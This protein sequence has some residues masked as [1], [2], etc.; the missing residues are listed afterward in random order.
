MRIQVLLDSL[1]EQ[2]ALHAVQS[3]INIT[4]G[5]SRPQIDFEYVYD[6]SQFVNSLGTYKIAAVAEPSQT[7]RDAADLVWPPPS[8]FTG[9]S[10]TN[11]DRK[12]QVW[13]DIQEHV[14]PAISKVASNEIDLK[15]DQND[16]M[17][18]LSMIRTAKSSY[19]LTL[20][21]GRR[22]KVSTDPDDGDGISHGDIAS[23]LAA[24]YLFGARGVAV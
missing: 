12:S 6:H 5:E 18:V 11:K 13:K 21:D 19:V 20:H 16:V 2:R 3:S 24:V 23:A 9:S 4:S 17:A 1:N 15:L 7:I 8:S 10:K 22:L 14:Y